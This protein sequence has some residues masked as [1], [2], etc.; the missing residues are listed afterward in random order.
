MLNIKKLSNSLL[1]ATALT[2]LMAT[3]AIV[4]TVADFTGIYAAAQD[5]PLASQQRADAA[6]AA[7]LSTENAKAWLVTKEGL[8]IFNWIITKA[9]L[10]LSQILV[11]RI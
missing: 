5:F 7:L 3:T 10:G 9:G 1:V 6:A 4:P 8:C 11:K 2:G